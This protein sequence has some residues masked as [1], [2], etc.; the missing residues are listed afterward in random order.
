VWLQLLWTNI[1]SNGRA[2]CILAAGA[3]ET[4]PVMEQRLRAAV[5]SPFRVATTVLQFSEVSAYPFMAKPL[6]CPN[7]PP[8]KSSNSD[9]RRPLFPWCSVRPLTQICCHGDTTLNPKKSVNETKTLPS[10]TLLLCVENTPTER[11]SP[12]LLGL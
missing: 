10:P 12:R 1:I 3:E 11:L 5:T 9:A 7:S 2:C 4:V 8:S 6:L